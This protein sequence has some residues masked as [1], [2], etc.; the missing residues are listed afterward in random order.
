MTIHGTC[1]HDSK[2]IRSLSF[3]WDKNQLTVETV[4]GKVTYQCNYGTYLMLRDSERPGFDLTYYV[5]YCYS[6]VTTPDTTEQD[7]RLSC[8]LFQAGYK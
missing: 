2:T 1:T 5:A 6:S 3:D 4:K 7:Y 8:A